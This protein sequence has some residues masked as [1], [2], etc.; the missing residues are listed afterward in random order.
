VTHSEAIGVVGYPTTLPPESPPST[1][2]STPERS[3][4]PLAMPHPQAWP[5][6]SSGLWCS[7]SLA[8]APASQIAREMAQAE[9]ARFNAQLRSRAATRTEDGDDG[10]SG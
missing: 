7:G 9:L 8:D 5:P 2:K 4:V 10:R 6:Q 3:A 1:E